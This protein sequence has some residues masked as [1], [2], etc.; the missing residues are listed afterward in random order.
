M[1]RK[2][3]VYSA[4]K[5]RNDV[6]NQ[7]RSIFTRSIIHSVFAHLRVALQQ[8]NAVEIPGICR[9]ELKRGAKGRPTMLLFPDESFIS[10]TDIYWRS[11]EED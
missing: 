2:L 8:Y 5:L 3:A 4:K 6:E 1:R 10:E 11:F 9:I 7:T